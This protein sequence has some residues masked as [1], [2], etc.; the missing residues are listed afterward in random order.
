MLSLLYIVGRRGYCAHLEGGVGGDVEGAGV[1]GG[2]KDALEGLF[3]DG[4]EEGVRL[5]HHAARHVHHRLHL[6][7]AHLAQEQ[8]PAISAPVCDQHLPLAIVHARHTK[9]CSVHCTFP[10]IRM[11]PK[12]GS[13]CES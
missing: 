4:V 1:A 5:H 8:E 6:R 9:T 2:H 12:E 13:G 10:R 3:E 11:K 7:Q